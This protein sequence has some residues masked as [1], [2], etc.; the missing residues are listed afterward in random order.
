[1][2]NRWKSK[3]IF[4]SML[5]LFLAGMVRVDRVFFKRNASFNVR[6]LFSSLP[7]RP[8]WDLPPPSP[9]EAAL[10]DMVLSQKFHYL[11]KGTHCYA[12]VSEDQNTVIK[13]HRYPSH[14]RIFPWLTHPFS[15]HFSERRK[16]ILKYN[17]ERLN[18]H[19]KNYKNCYQDLKKETGMILLHINHTDYLKRTVTL[20]DKTQAEY[21]VPLDDVSFILQHKA[22]LIY[23]TLDKLMAEKK[24]AEAK[25]VVSEIIGLTTACCKKGYVDNDPVLHRNYGLLADRAIHIDIGDMIK[26]EKMTQRE[27]YIPNVKEMTEGLRKRLESTYPELLEHYSQEISQL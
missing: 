27:N 9:K 16:Q 26:N 1:M 18:Y 25:K 23:P 4:L 7:N 8:E 20:V 11:G 19:L 13:F 10:L 12:F 5:V 3:L 6:F 22:N 2:N 14:M 15:Y 24:V 17:V 21:H